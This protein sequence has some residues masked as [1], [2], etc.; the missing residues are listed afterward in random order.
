[1]TLFLKPVDQH[2]LMAQSICKE[3]L[4][5]R[6]IEGRSVSGLGF[7]VQLGWVMYTTA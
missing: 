3:V 2:L 4:L 1:M 7:V 5:L 6:V